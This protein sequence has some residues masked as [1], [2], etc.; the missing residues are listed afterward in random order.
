MF[1]VFIIEP[2][3]VLW[4]NEFNKDKLEKCCWFD[5]GLYFNLNNECCSDE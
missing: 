5:Y 3:L 1:H 2:N 4:L